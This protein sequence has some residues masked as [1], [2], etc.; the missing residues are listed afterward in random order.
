MRTLSRTSSARASAWKAPHLK[1]R[2]PRLRLRPNP[3]TNSR[4]NPD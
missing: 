3:S 4:T 2:N 1:A